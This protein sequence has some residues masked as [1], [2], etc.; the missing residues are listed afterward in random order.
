MKK[1]ES[2]RSMIEMLGVLAII[3]VLSIGGLAGYTM[4]MN[5]H[6]ANTILDYISKCVVVAQTHGD[7]STVA[8][9]ACDVIMPDELPPTFFGN[10][11][12]PQVTLDG[13]NIHVA[14]VAASARIA[15][16]MENRSVPNRIVVDSTGNG[17][18][19]VDFIGEATGVAA[20]PV[21]GNNQQGNG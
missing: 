14:G 18:F 20:D 5:R 8:T 15:D 4:A 9:G 16:A 11:G 7:G 1:I 10:N 3:G 17:G 6:R 19:T 2:G 13:N 21:G 12:I